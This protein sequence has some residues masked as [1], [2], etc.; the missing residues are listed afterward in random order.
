MEMPMDLTEVKLRRKD[1]CEGKTSTV[2][3]DD[4]GFR[5]DDID[6]VKELNVPIIRYPG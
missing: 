1:G 5:K 3:V 2:H 4:D 6:L